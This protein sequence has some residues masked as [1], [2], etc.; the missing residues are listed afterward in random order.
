MRYPTNE[1]VCQTKPRVG[2]LS[3]LGAADRA[4]TQLAQQHDSQQAPSR[5][6]H[7]NSNSEPKPYQSCPQTA[8]ELANAVIPNEYGIDPA[9]KLRIGS[10]IC[11]SLLGKILADL[12]N[13]REE[14]LATAHID[15]R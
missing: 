11:S 3:T 13:M 1:A 9:G 4:C 15:V 12:A 5:N 14:S 2:R 7:S 6:P 10:K 8:K